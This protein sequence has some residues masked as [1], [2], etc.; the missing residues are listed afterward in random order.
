MPT[1]KN[2]FNFK[3]LENGNSIQIYF[4]LEATDKFQAEKKA[5]IISCKELKE[6]N[7]YSLTYFTITEKI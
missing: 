2:Q 6:I 3:N 4:E 1:F 7:L 5:I